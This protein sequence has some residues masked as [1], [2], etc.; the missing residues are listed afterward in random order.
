[1]PLNIR[2]LIKI[3][4]ATLTIIALC[5]AL[6]AVQWLVG[7]D[8][9][10][11]SSAALV[12]FG[13]NIVPLLQID[14]LYRWLTSGFVHIGVLH[15]LF[16]GFALYYFGVVSEQVLGSARFLAL[17]C[18]AVIGGN[19]LSDVVALLEIAQFSGVENYPQIIAGAS[20]G[21]MGLGAFLLLIGVLN[22]PTRFVLNTK[23]LALILALN[24]VMGFALDGINNAGHIGG[25]L[26]GAWLALALKWRAFWRLWAL[27]LVAIAAWLAFVY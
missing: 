18:A 25:A 3:A 1:M 22:I 14:Q 24:L 26:V 9:D 5:V 17:F 6:M 13:A 20:G 7:V 15:L 23:N 16:N 12:A 2:Q 8:I 27:L 21:V 11:P 10:Q 4:P 19:L